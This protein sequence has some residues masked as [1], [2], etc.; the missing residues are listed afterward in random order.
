MG[1]A[2]LWLQRNPPWATT[3]ATQT[4]TDHPAPGISCIR[5]LMMMN[6]LSAKEQGSE[7]NTADSEG[8]TIHQ[9]HAMEIT[10]DTSLA[11]QQLS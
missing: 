8:Q 9:S 3:E 6:T 5:E 4:R 10:D 1:G 11:K 7:E 2:A